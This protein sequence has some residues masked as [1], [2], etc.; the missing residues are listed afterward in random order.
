MTPTILPVAKALYLCDYEVGY[1]D[2]KV[3]LYGL[4]NA[5][6]PQTAFPYTC[7]QFCVFAQLVNGLGR[8]PFLIDIRFAQ[9]DELVWT[10]ELR[11]LVFPN[12]NTVVQLALT[13]EGCPFGRHGLYLLE[14]FCNNTWVCDAQLQLRQV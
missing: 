12:R 14:L 8:M 10:T 4:F 5:I 9:T 2:G 3:D 11:E 6:R 1:S 7:G 13:I